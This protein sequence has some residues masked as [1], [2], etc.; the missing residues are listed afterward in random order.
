MGW[1]MNR[2][3]HRGD[4]GLMYDE[5]GFFVYTGF[6]PFSEEEDVDPDAPEDD[7]AQE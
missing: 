4:D 5:D 2:K 7:D 6:S 3:L 1:P